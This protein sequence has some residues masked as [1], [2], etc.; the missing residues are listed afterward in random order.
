MWDREGTHRQKHRPVR[1]KAQSPGELK[2]TLTKIGSDETEKRAAQKTATFFA[3]T[4]ENIESDPEIL[5]LG[6]EERGCTRDIQG[7]VLWNLPS[8]QMHFLSPR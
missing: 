1:D 8:L 7:R 2:G 4:R 3:R 6:K 5:N